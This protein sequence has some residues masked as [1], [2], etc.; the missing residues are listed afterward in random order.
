MCTAGWC[1]RGR[2]YRRGMGPGWVAGWVYRVGNT[3]SQALPSRCSQGGPTPAKR[4]RSPLQGAEWW[5]WGR[6]RPSCIPT[7]SRP[8]QGL[9]GPASLG[10]TSTRAKGRLWPIKAR[11]R[12][13][14]R[15]HS[16]NGEVSTKYVNKACHSPCFPKRCQNSPLDFLR[17]PFCVAFSPKELMVPFCA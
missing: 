12:S 1:S 6:V 13:I 4:A 17:F 8:L 5:V 7:H 10:Y 3:G 11:L 15:K 2:V 9:P 16:Q 14:F